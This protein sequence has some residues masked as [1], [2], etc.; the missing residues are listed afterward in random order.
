MIIEIDS[1]L[2]LENKEIKIKFHCQTMRKRDKKNFPCSLESIEDVALM[3][4][5]KFCLRKHLTLSYVAT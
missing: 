2:H 4:S 3:F 5:R 1:I